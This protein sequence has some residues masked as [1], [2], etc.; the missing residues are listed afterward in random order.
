[1]EFLNMI[2]KDN[3]VQQIL[4]LSCQAH[5]S[6]I[7][8]ISSTWILPSAAYQQLISVFS[9]TDKLRISWGSVDHWGSSP[10]NGQRNVLFP[11][12]VLPHSDPESWAEEKL[13]CRHQIAL[14]WGLK[15]QHGAVPDEGVEFTA[16]GRVGVND[17]CQQDSPVRN[18]DWPLLYTGSVCSYALQL[19]VSIPTGAFW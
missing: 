9:E 2:V 3:T 5:E 14:L 13:S 7:Q 15:L 10:E 17:Q 8:D 6:L 16:G 11:W 12:T 1:M 18:N 4:E 19:H